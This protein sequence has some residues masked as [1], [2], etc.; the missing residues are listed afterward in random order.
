MERA[1]QKL[2][3]PA[4][5]LFVVDGVVRAKANPARAVSYG[6]LI[7]DGLK[8]QVDPKIALKQSS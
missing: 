4:S 6:E 3:V 2:G 1:A 8:V 5:E 7:G